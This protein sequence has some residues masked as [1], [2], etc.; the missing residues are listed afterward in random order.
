MKK[1]GMVRVAGLGLG[2]VMACCVGCREWF[3]RRVVTWADLVKQLGDF[4]RIARLDV[5]SSL[6]ITSFDPKGGNDDY[7]N[8]VRK[9]KTPGWVVLADLKGPGYMSRFWFT[10]A[11]GERPLRFYFDGEKKPR[12]ETTLDEFCA[13]NGPFFPIL[14]GNENICWYSFVPIPYHNR[15][16]I[17]AKE[18]GD[19]PGGWPRLFY[20]VNYASLPPGQT[21]ASFPAALSAEDLALLQKIRDRWKAFSTE[22][23]LP[24]PVSAET[25][26]LLKA[27]MAL[28]LFQIPGP[29]LLR[30]LWIQPD[31]DAITASA[32]A[33]ENILR[34]VVLR[35]R[36]NRLPAASV[37]VPLG[38]FFGSCWQRS[39]YQCLYFGLTNDT[40]IS[41]FPMPFEAS[42]RI[43][44]ENQGTQTI[45]LKAGV[46]F[47]PLKQWDPAWGYFHS[48][49]HRTGPEDLGKPHPVLRAK[50]RGKY[51]GCIMAV[52][53]AD[54][55][56]WMLEGDETIRKD[57]EEMP[58][59]RGTG[60]ED[61]F[62]GGWYYRNVLIRPLH[63]LPF[64]VPF[65]TVQ[66]SL[67]L[68][69]PTLFRSSLDMVFERGPDHA[70][71]GW[72]ESVAFYYMAQPCQ[73]FARLGAPAERLAPI[74]DLA[75]MTLMTELWNCERLGDFKGANDYLDRYLERY[76]D[77]P[78]AGVLRLRQ[79]AYAEREKGFDTVRPAYERIVATETNELVRQY[80]NILLWYQQSSSNAL[81]MAF[82]NTRTKVYL[83]GRE[84]GESGDPER[85]M[86]WGLQVGS[87]RHVLAMQAQWR[88]YPDW[89]QAM[90]RTHQGDVFTTMD[91]KNAINPTPGWLSPDYDDRSWKSAGTCKGPPD[92]PYVWVM[93]DPLVDVQSKAVGL[94]PG[95]EWPDHRGMIVYRKVFDLP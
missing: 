31:F 29:A 55:S 42:A 73:A 54:R 18:G 68:M 88:Q 14:A 51:V 8:F 57:N 81:L 36:W 59:W 3:P 35:I 38:D 24:G 10:G 89:N 82:A 9:S 95:S 63:G 56:Y 62:N 76:P 41:R 5:P 32:L 91:W 86:V 43:S 7:N 1:T 70:S 20:Q 66:Y 67:H 85:L 25:N 71:R 30:S 4:D 87:G 37:E 80:A 93:P 15:L 39:R 19:Q 83:D 78:F 12:I 13:K 77:F 52:S 23:P 17:E 27:G 16:I 75:R 2:L 46:G 45:A 64:K 58:A 48:G 26:V 94:S 22:R 74:E 11:G 69:N 21:V 65:R 60:L 72:M 47:E 53:S 34:E 6:I 92:E 40:L 79:L 90:L 61:Y 44:L 84:I 49:W 28:D 33:R 50:G